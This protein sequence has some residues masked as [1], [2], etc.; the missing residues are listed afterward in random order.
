VQV[1]D[2]KIHRFVEN[3]F[4]LQHLEPTTKK[5]I[6]IFRITFRASPNPSEG[7]GFGLFSINDIQSSVFDGLASPFR[8]EV[9]EGL[10]C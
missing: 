6:L 7:G 3:Y 8:G 5:V 9:G 4:V 2:V 1:F 10:F